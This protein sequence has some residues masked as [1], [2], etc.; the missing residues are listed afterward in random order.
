MISLHIATLNDV[1]VFGA[2][3]RGGG[4]SRAVTAM[5]RARSE[6][7]SVLVCCGDVLGGS[8]VAEQSRG[9]TPLRLIDALR[10]DIAALGN[11][12][13]DFGS[14]RLQELILESQTMWLCSNVEPLKGTHRIWVK[15]MEHGIKAGFF[16]LCTPSTA[17]SSFPGDDVVFEDPVV[18]A[19]R[20]VRHLREEL[21][22]ALVVAVTHM[23]LEEDKRL[24]SEVL[25]I[26]LVLGGHEHQPC[27]ITHNGVLV[28]KCGQNGLWVGHVQIDI[29][30]DRKERHISW[31]LDSTHSESPDPE[32]MDILSRHATVDESDENLEFPLP[33]TLCLDTRSSRVRTGSCSGGNLVADALLFGMPGADM[34]VINGGFIRGDRLYRAGHI[35]TSSDLE[36]EFP[37]PCAAVLLEITV[38][39]LL[40][41]LCEHLSSWPNASPS[42]PH[43]SHNVRV[44]FGVDCGVR[45]WLDGEEPPADRKVRVALSGFMASGGDKCS[46]WKRGNILLVMEDGVLQRVKEL[47]QSGLRVLDG[48]RVRRVQ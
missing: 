21:D 37:F 44:E 24:V 23:F 12:E 18:A 8:A 7:G 28:L 17:H 36:D 6:R 5:R 20:L 26:D 46:S 2:P 43:V 3:S 40:S 15:H 25:G 1:Y 10:P 29:S 35:L 30:L 22:C 13:F 14:N 16:A 11:H 47:L 19:Q 42:F 27:A 38:S 41:A 48:M 33:D 45:L 34:G 32:C 31:R 4:F 39:D 9:H